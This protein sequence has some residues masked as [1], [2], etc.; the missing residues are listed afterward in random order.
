M[1]HKPEMTGGKTMEDRSRI[2][3]G[4]DPFALFR[5]WLAEAEEN[6]PNDPNAMALAT[7]DSQGIPNVRMVLLKEIETNGLV[8]FTNLASVKAREI[9]RSGNAALVIHWKSIRRQIRARGQVEQVDR[10]QSDAYFA[11]RSP[12]SRIGA[13]ASFQSQPLAD[14]T[15]LERRVEQFRRKLGDDPPRPDFWGGFRITP[16]EMEF[17]SNR[18]DRLHDRFRWTRSGAGKGWSVERL[19]P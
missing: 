12:A 14:R 7:V 17:W 18:E 4:Q 1:E 5:S 13:W 11:T 16:F 15:L 10:S 9:A 3:S 2:F 8:F 6:E 19:N